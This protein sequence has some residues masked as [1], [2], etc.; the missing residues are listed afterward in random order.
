MFG[1]VRLKTYVI[2]SGRR[3]IL[4]VSLL[5]RKFTTAVI[6]L[7]ST[8]I[9]NQLITVVKVMTRLMFIRKVSN[10]IGTRINAGNDSRDSS[11]R[12]GGVP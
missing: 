4:N 10:M 11:T 5:N 8:R 3:I 12:R 7:R 9:E 1:V 6:L 2:L